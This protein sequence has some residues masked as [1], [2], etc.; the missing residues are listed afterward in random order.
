MSKCTDN[1]SL[2]IK[3]GNIK[4]KPEKTVKQPVPTETKTCKKKA[5]K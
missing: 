4:K 2:C 1:C 3:M 5:S